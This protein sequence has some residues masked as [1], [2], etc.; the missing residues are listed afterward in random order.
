M[1]ET[2]QKTVTGYRDAMGVLADRSMRQALYEQ[3][4]VVMDDV[5]LSL[6]GEE[7]RKRRVLEFKVFRKDFFQYYET[8]IFPSALK[9]VLGPFEARG[10]MDLVDFGYRVTMNLTADFA[11]VD[12]PLKTAHETEQLLKLVKIFS[13]AA[14]VVHSKL[15]KDDVRG[16]ALSALETLREVFVQPSIAR[17]RALLEQLKQGLLTEADL[18]RDV[19]M[20]LLQNED[21]L[22]LPDEV[23][24]RE[25]AFYLQA[26]SHST[27]NSMIHALHEIF[28]YCDAHPGALARLR[29]DPIFLQRCVHESL[30]LHPASPV[31]WRRPESGAGGCPV[32]HDAAGMTQNRSDLVIVELSVANRDK[33]IFGEDADSFNPDRT[34]PTDVPP[35]GLTFGYGLHMCLG[36]DLDGGIAPTAATDPATHQY[37]IVTH[38]IRTLLALNVRRDPDDP[39]TPD[40]QSERPNWGR[41]PVLIERVGGQA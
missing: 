7:H 4:G 6:H 20:L 37:G 5:L 23:V 9:E 15:D 33:A 19:L 8:R 24:L 21:K 26:G 29:S 35:W 17:R 39:A 16:E 27:A 22:A 10:Q 28:M 40:L 2:T 38:L 41:Y 11:G 36:R 13:Q 25:M 32:H 3:G 1:H 30:R 14:T 31:A 18:P 12:R 34:L